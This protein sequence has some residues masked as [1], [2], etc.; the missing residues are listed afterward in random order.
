MDF[1]QF[2][3][4]RKYM[5]IKAEG[6]TFNGKSVEKLI[7]VRYRT[8]PEY[9]DSK[10]Y[11]LYLLQQYFD[12]L[13][14]HLRKACMVTLTTEQRGMSYPQQYALIQSF[15][16]KWLNNL[17]QYFPGLDW[18]VIA[19][20]HKS[21]YAHYHI[22]FLKHLDDFEQAVISDLW[23]VASGSYNEH[24]IHFANTGE[25][26]SVKNYLM[27]YISK[28]LNYENPQIDKV[29]ESDLKRWSGQEYTLHIEV[30]NATLW[31]LNSHSTDYHGF[32]AIQFSHNLK[33]EME[34]LRTRKDKTVIHW[35][36]FTL[37]IKGGQ[38]IVI[39]KKDKAFPIILEWS[40]MLLLGGI[41][42]SAPGQPVRV[43]VVAPAYIPLPL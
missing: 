5:H 21:G 8:D 42:D 7:P 11:D 16:A 3:I 33:A 27:K 40:E 38:E 28:G 14:I 35:H 15:K 25:I 13:P 9:K 20:P 31:L 6:V 1:R 43:P 19:E 12:S 23:F 2:E 39:R 30:F 17:K 10:L 24:S 26:R 41:P 22:L 34:K 29:P 36:T 37:Q 32:R 4:D 18:V